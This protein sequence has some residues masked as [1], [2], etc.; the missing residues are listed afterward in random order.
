MGRIV[1]LC[2][3]PTGDPGERL[4]SQLILGAAIAS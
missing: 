3:V 2:T 1:G 4:G